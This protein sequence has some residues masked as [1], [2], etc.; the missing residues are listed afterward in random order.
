MWADTTISGLD[1][2]LQVITTVG[3]G[4]YVDL[5]PDSGGTV[6]VVVGEVGVAQPGASLTGLSPTRMIDSRP[7][8][9]AAGGTTTFTAAPFAAI[10][11]DALAVVGDLADIQPTS[12]GYLVAYP[13]GTTMPG[14]ANIAN[15]PGQT[16]ST[17][18]LAAVNPANGMVS[19]SSVGASTTFTFDA[20]AYIS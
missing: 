10:P 13:G 1:G 15:Y 3:T 20:T 5:Y 4:G 9:V 17:S 7:G 14:T 19:V 12:P 8:G 2:S 16:R 6:N 18:V 11:S